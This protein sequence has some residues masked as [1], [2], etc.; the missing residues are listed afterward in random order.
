[1][2]LQSGIVC[3]A[4]CWC[5]M[6]RNDGVTQNVVWFEISNHN[7]GTPYHIIFTSN[8]FRVYIFII[9]PDHI[10]YGVMW[11]VLQWQTDVGCCALF[12]PMRM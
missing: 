8:I 1:M 10:S 3:C 5:A 9:P 12:I 7:S 6:V 2:V 4:R 11:N